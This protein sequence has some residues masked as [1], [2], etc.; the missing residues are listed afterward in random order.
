MY[1]LAGDADVE[2]QLPGRA[3]RTG[4]LGGVRGRGRLPAQLLDTLRAVQ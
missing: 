4:G 3:G 2:Q 1:V